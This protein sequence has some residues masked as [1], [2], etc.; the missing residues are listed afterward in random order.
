MKNK[1]TLFIAEIL[2]ITLLIL[3]GCNNTNKKEKNESKEQNIVTLGENIK[4]VYSNSI[5]YISSDKKTLFV[6]LNNFDSS[7]S[8]YVKDGIMKAIENE[9]NN[10]KLKECNK[11]ILTAFITNGEMENQLF[12]KEIYSMPELKNESSRNY[13]DYSTF[14]NL[15]D[16]TIGDSSN[17]TTTQKNIEKGEDITLT[18]GRYIVGEDIKA[19]KYD[20]VAQSGAGNFFVRGNNS[21]NEMMGVGSSY[22]IENYSNARLEPG[23]EVEVTSDLKVQLKAK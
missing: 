22:Y 6:E 5:T 20:V 10:N 16:L 1:K 14:S 19:G 2:L 8:G 17:K 9:I 4:N 12:I 15:Y 18:A 7:Q 11:F 3:T 21:V 23:N 13:I